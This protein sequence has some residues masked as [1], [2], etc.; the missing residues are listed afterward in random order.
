MPRFAANLST[1]FTDRLFLDRFAA[2]HRAG[3]DAVEC[4]F[5]YEAAPVEVR[6]RLDDLGLEMVLLNT[7]PGDF[8][9][10]E[11][12]LAALPGREA[13]FR[14]ALDRALDYAVALDVP[15]VH[16]MA[17]IPPAGAAR[18][19]CLAVY[20]ANLR[21]AAEAAERA[22]RR[23][24]IEPLNPRD[25]PGYLL[26]SPADGA[27]VIEEVGHPN[28]F[29]QLDLYHTQITTGD[30][31]RT[32]E[33]HLPISA[34]VQVAGVPGRHEPDTGE[35]RYPYLFELLDGL[36]YRGWIG[37]EYVPRT[38]TEE[39]LSWAKPYGIVPRA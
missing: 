38:G 13:D 21:H 6:A 19:D 39:G 22:G 18:E 27:A 9:A 14:A 30:L 8:A 31:A 35:V 3:F 37:T 24:L 4:Q 11:R 36:G 2:A 16:C 7:P 23:L 29:L 17:G 10:G 34:H 25:V 28:L 5:P 32:V 12:G 20:R 15:N 26:L 1:M 33:R